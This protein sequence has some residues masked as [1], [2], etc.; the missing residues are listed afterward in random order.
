M[1]GYEHDEFKKWNIA[2]SKKQDEMR[3]KA[4]AIEEKY[5]RLNRTRSCNLETFLWEIATTNGILWEEK[6]EDM[7]VYMEHI[8][9]EAQV[10]ALVDILHIYH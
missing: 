4:R 5:L 10:D 1:T 9:A 2:I 3:E 8:K 7:R 6:I